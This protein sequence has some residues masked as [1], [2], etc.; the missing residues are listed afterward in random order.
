MSI[1]FN[2]AI[3]VLAFIVLAIS[4]GFAANSAVRVAGLSEFNANEKLKNA[5]TNL[6]WASVIGFI[7]VALLI[8]GGILYLIFTPETIEISAA[9][10]T[11]LGNLAVYGLLFLALVGII[12]VGVYSAIAANDIHQSGVADNKLSYRNSIISASLAIIAFVLLL[13]ALLI[14]FFYKPK[15]KADP[16][17]KTLEAELAA[18][19]TEPQK[20]A[21]PFDELLAKEEAAKI[22]KPKPKLTRL[23]FLKA[24]AQAF[25]SWF[26]SEIDTDPELAESIL[27]D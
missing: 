2:F 25:P 27:T 11:S 23:Q 26:R 22:A 20:Y 10:G 4:A 5:H 13:T 19:S 3:L 6:T 16:E 15:V 1:Y 12:L 18:P 24:K 14:K 7:T 9:T 17:I 21:N 8:V